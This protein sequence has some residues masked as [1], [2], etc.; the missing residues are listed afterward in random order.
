MIATFYMYHFTLNEECESILKL[1]IPYKNISV[2][3]IFNSQGNICC[4]TDESSFGVSSGSVNL[5]SS[6]SDDGF[7]L[8]VMK[9]TPT[10]DIKQLK[11]THTYIMNIN[12]INYQLYNSS[13]SK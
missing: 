11:Y 9:Y 7:L 4:I 6:F 1:R 8:I 10:N 12:Y 13:Y 2:D 5:A 3:K